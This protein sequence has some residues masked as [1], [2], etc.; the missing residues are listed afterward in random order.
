MS[1]S[2]LPVLR[3]RQSARLATWQIVVVLGMSALFASF[4]TTRLSITADP[5]MVLQPWLLNQ[6]FIPYLQIADEHSPLLPQ[7]LA[8]VQTLVDNH[9]IVALRLSHA[10]TLT[11][12]FTLL[13][14]WLWRRYGLWAMVAG[15]AF[16]WAFA[17]R[18]GL[19]TF[20]YNLALAPV[21]LGYFI[22]LS[23]VSSHK[24]M[25]RVFWGGI[26]LGIGLLL[27]QQAIVLAPAFAGWLVIT[28][29]HLRIGWRTSIQLLAA[30]CVAAVI[31][32][33]L[34]LVY[35]L[36]VG[37][38][39]AA[40]VE[41]IVWFN[42][43][44][45]Y[46]RMGFLLPTNLDLI[47]IWPAF[48]LALPF[49]VSTIAPGFLEQ[50]ERSVRLWLLICAVSS[51]IFLYPR[52][53]VPHWA[54]AFAFVAAMTAIVCADIVRLAC[55][56]PAPAGR[57]LRLVVASI[58]LYWILHGAFLLWPAIAGTNQPRLLKFDEQQEL[59]E[60]LK[61][62]LPANSTLVFIPDNEAISNAYYGLQRTPPRFWMMHYP[63]FMQPAVRERW[64]AELRE[65]PPDYVVWVDGLQDLE[66]TGPEVA[67]FV[68]EYYTEV[69]TFVWQ[70]HMVHVLHRN[71]V[72]GQK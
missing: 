43:S 11:L 42:L 3:D 44:S 60:L 63:W 55:D 36:A 35:Y 5:R 6:G 14:G 32:I 67:P 7:L 68:A 22:L 19:T 57:F 56:L 51:L 9:G 54:A 31:P 16:I 48:V 1:T 23:S 27:K 33:L 21:F 17:V 50:H 64:L 12:L 49:A 4:L 66:I 28:I 20:W 45:G 2:L 29:W 30:F 69:S 58:V 40:F 65:N 15:F 37:G 72:E 18:F 52:Y 41:W 34:Y 62:E 61:S 25:K 8:W 26:L 24:P 59:A 71:Q 39:I 46:A 13:T 10:V 70:G 53:S 47:T 38:D